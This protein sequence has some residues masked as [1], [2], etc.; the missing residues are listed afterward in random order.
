MKKSLIS[1]ILA[2]SMVFSVIGCSSDSSSSS[3]SSKS[4][5]PSISN[6]SSEIISSSENSSTSFDSNSSMSSSPL[7]SSSQSSQSSITSSSTTSSSLISSSSS[8]ISS[9]SI[10][11][12]SWSTSSSVSSTQSSSSSLES[13]SSSSSVA[14]EYDI[15]TLACSGGSVTPSKTKAKEGETITLSVS[16]E[17]NYLL[18]WLSVK[19]GT[20]NIDLTNNSFV[21][22]AGSV[23]ISAEFSQNAYSIKNGSFNIDGQSI[24]SSQTQSIAIKNGE[25]FTSGTLSAKV[26]ASALGDNGIIFRVTNPNNLT[27]F[28]E[29]DVSYYF[30]FIN[31]SQAYLGKVTQGAWSVCQ[32]AP[33]NAIAN[34]E[35]TLSVSVDETT[36]IIRCLVNDTMVFSFKDGSLLSGNNY[37]VRSATS[38][39]TY[40]S[41][42]VTSAVKGQ[43]YTLADF[44][45]ASGTA[46]EANGQITTT[47]SNT[48]LVKT[49]ENFK[50]GYLQATL[51][52]NGQKND[53]GIIFGLSSNSST[54][55]EGVGTSY[56]LFFISQVGTVCLAK[57]VDNVWTHITDKPLQNYS[58]SGTYTMKLV[59]DNTLIYCY[60]NDI[61]Y[62]TYAYDNSVAGTGWGIRVGGN[63]TVISN[64]Q[65][66]SGYESPSST[67][68]NFTLAKG[69]ISGSN[70]L[71]RTSTDTVALYKDNLNAGKFSTKIIANSTEE[72]GVVFGYKDA[73]NYYRF[74]TQK[75]SQTV[76]V[77]KVVNG[78]E[79]VL[80]SNF[81][82]AG[83]AT[84]GNFYFEVTLTN[85][86]AY[87]Y[88]FNTRYAVV[89]ID[90]SS[91]SKIGVFSKGA[92][93]VVNE[94]A[95]STDQTVKTVD[96]LLFGHSYFELWHNW[97]QDLKDSN[98]GSYTN[99]G[100]GGSVASQWY[101]FRE[102]ILSYQPSRVIYMIG[103]NDLTGGVTPADTANSVE[104]LLLYLKQNIPSLEVIL[105]G[106]NQCPARWTDS[107]YDRVT[108]VTSTNEL[109]REIVLKYDEWIN[110]VELEWAFADAPNTKPN[111]SWFSD[112]LHLNPIGY[113][114]IVVPAIEAAIR[115]ENQPT[116]TAKDFTVKNGAFTQTNGV[117]TSGGT[118][119]LAIRKDKS[120]TS[121]TL[122]VDMTVT[123]LGADNGIVFRV[124]NPSNASAFWEA[125]VSYYFF[126]LS[127]SQAY[128]GKVTNGAWSAL[129][130]APFA[131]SAG[132]KYTLAVSIDQSTNIIRC[133]INGT[134]ACSYKEN[135]ILS[136]TEY[137][138]RAGKE[139]IVF[140]GD[141][142][143]S[144]ILGTTISPSEFTTA[145]GSWTGA[146][147]TM[148]SSSANAI[149]VKNGETFKYGYIET[150][151]TLNGSGDNGIIFGLSSNSSTFWEHDSGASYY[152]FFIASAN[153][154]IMLAKTGATSAWTHFTD[155]AINNFSST[156]TYKLKVVRDANFIYGYVNDQLYITLA[157]TSLSGTGYGIRAGASGIKFTGLT[158]V[159]GFENIPHTPSSLT[160]TLGALYGSDSTFKTSGGTIALYN[161]YLSAGTVSVNITANSNQEAGI[162]FGYKNAQNYYRFYSQKTTQSI[163]VS[164]VQNGVETLVYT[165]YMSAGYY[166]TGS[167]YYSV[168]LTGNKAYC[169]FYNTRYAVIDLDT[170]SPSQVGIY[171]QG[172]AAVFN[173]FSA[174]TDQTL[175][176]VDTLLFGHSYFELWHN[177][178]ADLANSN[179]GTYTNVG[180]GGSQAS[181]WYIMKEASVSFNPKTVIYMIGINDLTAGVSPAN[182]M[183]S[184]RDT[185]LYMK[186]QLPDLKVILLGVNQCPARWSDSAYNRVAEITKTNELYRQLVCD[187]DEWINFVELEW[188]F[189]DSPNT[190]PIDSWFSDKLH[191]NPIGYTDIVVPAI[192]AAI[193]GENQPTADPNSAAQALLTAKQIKIDGLSSY[194]QS[195][196]RASEWA[197]AKPIYEEA[198][199]KINSC[200]TRAQVDLLDLSPYTTQLDAIKHNGDY[201]YSEMLNLTYNNS[202][203]GQS[204]GDYLW[205]TTDFTNNLIAN[206][207]DGYYYLGGTAGHRLNSSTIYQD[208][209]F[210]FMLS[211]NTG[212]IVEG[213]VLFLA[214]QNSYLGIDGYF[215]NI[216]TNPNYIQ[217]WYFQNAYTTN[218]GVVSEI[219]TYLGGWVFP[220]EVENTEFR[221]IVKDGFISIYT[222][223][224]Y[225]RNGAEAYGCRVNLG[226]K[227]PLYSS[228]HYGLLF[229]N[230]GSA[231]AK[232]HISD[233]CGYGENLASQVT[234]NIISNTNCYS[235]NPNLITDAGN[236]FINCA[237]YSY[238]I[239]N[240]ITASDFTMTVNTELAKTGVI[241]KGFFFRAT[242]N[243]SNDGVDGYIVNFVAN[244]N[245]QYLQ[246]FYAKNCY[247]LDGSASVCEYIGGWVYASSLGTMDG[248]AQNNPILGQSVTISVSGNT[249]T[250]S[251]SGKG[252]ITLNLDGSSVG[253]SFTPYSQG[254]FGVVSWQDNHNL[255]LKIENL[256]IY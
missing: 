17:A 66:L 106:V 137:G 48:L 221:A 249:F 176:T 252:S 13:S 227:Y 155:V 101:N 63:G 215:I 59:R 205:E 247:A 32:T 220:G 148:T 141:T 181:H 232:L 85:N 100:I 178:K 34:T 191:L 98:L 175:L 115:G 171:S 170:T 15:I 99:I 206:S 33:F 30:F 224:A 145:S 64:A 92:N 144:T 86:K 40:N 173:G 201:S 219:K 248:T 130:T 76:K 52:L 122:S 212:D 168:I 189:A 163:K 233:I 246:L 75:T 154:R 180:I 5:K 102:A 43:T 6:S 214:K 39:V 194:S 84:N 240:G 125:G 78:T 87:C 110:F 77:S 202:V 160:A 197:T 79:T 105:L 256:F 151:V 147:N 7:S 41:F 120:F 23:T 2:F 132:T 184:V 27:E 114:D 238:S 83:Y 211:D 58:L 165:N 109:Y 103:I 243:A 188:A 45:L 166:N 190:K 253:K 93:A 153:G 14:E 16:P 97:N 199:N 121:G 56:Y 117:Y 139:G 241:V 230:N 192:E 20:T 185:L 104:S 237:N 3:S 8:S 113:T 226:E 234:S 186:E 116:A 134:M 108:Q 128:L 127:N 136:G 72:T 150:T 198:I 65:N 1:L 60:V 149:T 222:E 157:D 161:T 195:G 11:S 133:F 172:S 179:L 37:G 217:V 182:T 44:S 38:G 200:T 169:H 22:P 244:E 12:S 4:K 24:T 88:F 29:Q 10:T 112:K 19:M 210:K 55:W 90:T 255:D 70:E 91:S 208:M 203:S 95:T 156:G 158:N 25:T 96:T 236:G 35:Y 183:Y 204:R 18:V 142:T 73:N 193:R 28:W 46:Q 250:A 167:F 213:G 124:T 209:D 174:T 162:V 235:E 129:Q 82:S 196:F 254:G 126:F 47:S 51:T 49:N 229:W 131:T 239:Y 42:T 207:K 146:T 118:Q 138:I 61:L 231:T 216:V 71:F 119:S 31:A 54:F 26:K 135:T 177:W 50:F 36:N 159:S 53:N 94:F 123:T 68:T 143:S 89:D 251:I 81:L 80:Y 245:E 21:M 62:L 242:K 107:A 57:T 187:Y 140:T 223:D 164:R 218:T 111:A 152:F 67:P 225:Q 74:F 228:G 69:A 9:S